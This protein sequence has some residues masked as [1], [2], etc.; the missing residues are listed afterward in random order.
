[1]KNA[2]KTSIIILLLTIIVVAGISLSGILR[3]MSEGQEDT[4]R[5][6]ERFC[7]TQR[8]FLKE[9]INDDVLTDE[10]KRGAFGRAIR[11]TQIANCDPPIEIPRELAG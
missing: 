11:A 4:D 1:M 5:L 7:N 6:N 10:Q 2:V 9:I 8:S 3:S